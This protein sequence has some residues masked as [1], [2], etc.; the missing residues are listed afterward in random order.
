MCS[1]LPRLRSAL[2]TQRDS[3]QLNVTW[4][5]AFRV[6]IVPSVAQ[7]SSPAPQ[8]PGADP[9]ALESARMGMEC[10]CAP[11]QDWEHGW[12]PSQPSWFPSVSLWVISHLPEMILVLMETQRS[13]RLNPW[14]GWQESATSNQKDLRKP[15]FANEFSKKDKTHQVNSLLQMGMKHLESSM[16]HKTLGSADSPHR[17]RHLCGD[18]FVKMLLL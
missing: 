1:E 14:A 17:A 9:Q 12:T 11:S 18:R 6:K 7:G 10:C 16:S 4:L 13:L 3:K 15:T 8:K 2:S 5:I